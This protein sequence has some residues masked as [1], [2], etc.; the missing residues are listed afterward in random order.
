MKSEFPVQACTFSIVFGMVFL[1]FHRYINVFLLC[2]KKWAL[3]FNFSISKSKKNVCFEKKKLSFV[4][5]V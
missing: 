5:A 4:P 3:K 2:P 1:I